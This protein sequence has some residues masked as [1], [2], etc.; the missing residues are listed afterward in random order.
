MKFLLNILDKL[1]MWLRLQRISQQKE[2][3]MPLDIKPVDEDGSLSFK[4]KNHNDS[5]LVTI[6][7]PNI[8][9]SSNSDDIVDISEKYAGFLVHISN[10]LMHDEVVKLLNTALEQTT[11]L[12]KQLFLKNTL[13]FLPILE[14]ELEQS[15]I[16][17]YMHNQPMIRPVN[18]FNHH[19]T[20]K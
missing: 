9:A 6:N 15:L 14:N 17:K 7:T 12:N 10:G 11:D 13:Y 1:L 5:I 20:S 2:S 16:A 4:F 3:L 8:S 18:V 19:H